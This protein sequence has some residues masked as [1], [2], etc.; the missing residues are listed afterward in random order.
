MLYC[1]SPLALARVVFEKDSSNDHKHFRQDERLS[2]LW[3]FVPKFFTGLLAEPLLV[4]SARAHALGSSQAPGVL[5]YAVDRDYQHSSLAAFL[6]PH[7]TEFTLGP[8]K[9]PAGALPGYI[10]VTFGRE[11]LE[12]KNDE[13]NELRH[14][15]GPQKGKRLQTGRESCKWVSH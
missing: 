12:S 8:D 5:R 2:L 11:L 3:C 10:E 13:E 1:C 4:L 14:R 7:V 9:P 6:L 15:K